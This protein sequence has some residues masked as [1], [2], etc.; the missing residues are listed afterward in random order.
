MKKFW[1]CVTGLA[2]LWVL[3]LGVE[4]GVHAQLPAPSKEP[5]TAELKQ[6]VAEKDLEIAKL[7][8]QLIQTEGQ[9]YSLQAQLDLQAKQAAVDA[10]A[11]KTAKK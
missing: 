5:T 6:Q 1:L 10:L 3:F 8:L 4:I 9:L 2:T 7:K 11:P